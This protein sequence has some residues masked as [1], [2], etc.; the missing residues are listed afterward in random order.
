MV[1]ATNL[2]AALTWSP[3]VRGVLVVAVGVAVLMGSVYLIMA[4]NSGA[5]LGFLLALTGLMG[6]MTMMGLVWSIYGIGRQGDPA[7]WQV[8]ETSSD[9]SQTGIGVARDLPVP[10][11][12]PTPESL[13]AAD[14]ALSK[15]FPAGPSVK[16]PNL[17]DLLGVK[18]ELETSIE[19]ELPKGWKLLATSDP[20]TG[21]AQ[22]AASAYLTEVSNKFEATTDFVVL[23]AF[24]RGGK[25]GLERGASALDRAWFKIKRVASWPLGHP[26]HYGV[27]QVQRVVAQETLPGEAPPLPI[28]DEA[29]PVISV[30]MERDLGTKRLPSVMVTIFSGLVF[31]ICC[32]TLHRR[33]R[34]VTEARSAAQALVKA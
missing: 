23:E 13:L 9:L 21:E 3:G 18:P 1:A 12:L 2:L 15:Q 5:R 28:A 17:G 11:D 20:Q 22:A 32:N 25:P 16:R 33:D 27:V 34:L 30:I 8:R 29:Q 7:T 31:A 26:P 24:S 10:D 19:T 4:T 14:P 6:W